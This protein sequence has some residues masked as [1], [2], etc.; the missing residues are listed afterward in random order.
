LRG[1]R[2]RRWRGWCVGAGIVV[3]VC[4]GVAHGLGHGAAD[5]LVSAWPA[6]ALAG[7]SNC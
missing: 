5:A 7:S 1:G 2:Y 6:L 4:A 3:T